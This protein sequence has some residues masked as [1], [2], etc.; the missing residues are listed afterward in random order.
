MDLH[1]DAILA[2]LRRIARA[3]DFV[4]N[5]VMDAAHAAFLTRDLDAELATLIADSRSSPAEA[6]RAYEPARAEDD[7]VQGRWLLS[8]A[9][10]GVQIDLEIDDDDGHVRLLGLLSGA[11]VTECEV[12][13]KL[14]SVPVEV[15]DL[16]R[17]IVAD[18]EH[19][20]IRLRCRL[21]DGR[22]VTTTWVR[23]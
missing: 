6:A 15:D 3:V 17:F 8:F 7:S 13:A 18:L 11:E 16:G 5:T 23:V 4:P 1:D 2:A 20:P 10:G 14:R 12:Q 19:G 22:R 21:I 9:G